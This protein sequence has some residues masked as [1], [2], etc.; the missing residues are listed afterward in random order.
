LSHLPPASRSGLFAR[1]RRSVHAGG[2]AINRIGTTAAATVSIEDGTNAP[3]AINEPMD[4]SNSDVSATELRAEKLHGC[5]AL[6]RRAREPV[7]KAG[8]LSALL[9]ERRHASHALQP[10]LHLV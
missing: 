5:D 3:W 1:R 7:A 10:E 2:A 6:F 4:S 8:P 9:V